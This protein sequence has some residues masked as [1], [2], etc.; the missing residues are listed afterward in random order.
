MFEFPKLSK[1]RDSSLIALLILRH[2][3]FANSPTPSPYFISFRSP[4]SPTNC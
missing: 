4:L 3:M 1:I 2:F